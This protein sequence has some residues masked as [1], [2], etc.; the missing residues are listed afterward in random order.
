MC[1]CVCAL[2]YALSGRAVSFCVC[3]PCWQPSGALIQTCFGPHRNAFS[4]LYVQCVLSRGRSSRGPKS[5]APLRTVLLETRFSASVRNSRI[6][7]TR[8]SQ[9][10]L[11]SAIHAVATVRYYMGETHGLRRL[12]LPRIRSLP[13]PLI[14]HLFSTTC[15]PIKRRGLQYTKL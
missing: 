5:T 12:Y 15:T 9:L 2:A 13:A 11:V 4:S 1:V 7:S 14:G 10:W 3:V 6:S 8:T